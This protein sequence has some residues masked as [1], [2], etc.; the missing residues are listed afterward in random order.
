MALVELQELKDNCNIYNL[1]RISLD[2]LSLQ[3]VLR[4]CLFESS[5]LRM[6]IYCWQLNKVIVKKIYIIPR[7]Y[8]SF[9][10]LQVVNFFSNI[11]ILLRNNQLSVK[12]IDIL[13]TTF[14]IRYSYYE[15]F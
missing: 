6:S 2:Q 13:K 15:F 10:Q 1:I 11:D 14:Q 8:D 7:K 12:E 5:S 3:G 9:D 4:C